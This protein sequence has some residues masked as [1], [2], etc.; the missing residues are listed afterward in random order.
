MCDSLRSEISKT[1]NKNFYLTDKYNF[2]YKQYF[3]IINKKDFYHT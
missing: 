3:G 1:T 2:I